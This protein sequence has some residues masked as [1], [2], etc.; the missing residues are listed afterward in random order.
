ECGHSARCPAV[1]DSP[2]PAA[3][4]RIARVLK[5]DRVWEVGYLCER[6]ASPR[7]SLRHREK[8]MGERVTRIARAN[9][10]GVMGVCVLAA[11]GLSHPA[12]HA[13]VAVHPAAARVVGE[14]ERLTV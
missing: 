4:A 1:Y 5:A 11:V 13:A 12:A 2:N 8:E 7:H 9:R 3:I 6:D 10:V 14:M